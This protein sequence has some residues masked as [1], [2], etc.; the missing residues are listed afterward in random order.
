M[1]LCL[2]IWETNLIETLTKMNANRRNLCFLSRAQLLWPTNLNCSWRKRVTKYEIKWQ[3]FKIYRSKT[4][5]KQAFAHSRVSGT[6]LKTHILKLNE[7]MTKMG[8]KT[9]STVMFR[10][11][12]QKWERRGIGVRVMDITRYRQNCWKQA[13][14]SKFEAKN[15]IKMLYWALYDSSIFLIYI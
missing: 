8:G 5:L 2:Y 15:N 6:K 13:F 1:L 7:E 9:Y 14:I 3:C 11:G 12:E 4:K 10:K